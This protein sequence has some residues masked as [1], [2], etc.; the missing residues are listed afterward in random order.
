MNRTPSPHMFATTPMDFPQDRMA[1][2]R[3]D[4]DIALGCECANPALQI[5]RWYQ[6]SLAPMSQAN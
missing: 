1:P 6:E 4:D 2:Q 5:E 3:I